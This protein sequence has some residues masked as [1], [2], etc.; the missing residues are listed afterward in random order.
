MASRLITTMIG[1]TCQNCACPKK[2]FGK[3]DSK[4][5]MWP[6][7][8]AKGNA[9]FGLLAHYISMAISPANGKTGC[10]KTAITPCADQ[11]SQIFR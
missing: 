8:A 11:G 10:R 1:M 2:L 4:Q 6:C 7:G 3:H 5:H 9:A